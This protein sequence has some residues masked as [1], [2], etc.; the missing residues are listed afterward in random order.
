MDTSE[1]Y[2]KQIMKLTIE[3]VPKTSWYANLRKSLPKRW[4]EIRKLTYQYYN[5]HCSICGGKGP[6]WPVE[7]HEVWNYSDRLHIQALVAL[8]ALCPACHLVKH[9]GFARVSGRLHEAIQQLMKV[10]NIDE[11][12]ANSEI[13]KAMDRWEE[14]SMFTWEVDTSDLDFILQSMKT[15][16]DERKNKNE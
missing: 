16:V 3:L 6:K 10:N 2:I 15:V 7:C 1:V 5:Y 12:A 13:S 14:R 9:I 8:Q 4:N 11:R